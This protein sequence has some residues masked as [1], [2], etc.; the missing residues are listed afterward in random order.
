M[1]RAIHSVE[2]LLAHEVVDPR[3]VLSIVV[4]GG[5]GVDVET[6]SH[7]LGAVIVTDTHDNGFDSDCTRNIGRSVLRGGD[8]VWFRDVIVVGGY[9]PVWSRSRFPDKVPDRLGQ[10]VDISRVLRNEAGITKLADKPA[11]R[12]GIGLGDDGTLVCG[13]EWDSE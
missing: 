2:R 3:L 10:G 13:E 12:K 5:E 7:I 4:G 1:G 11:W 8:F 6:C 9:D